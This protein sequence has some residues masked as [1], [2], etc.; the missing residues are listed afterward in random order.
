MSYSCFSV[1]EFCVSFVCHVLLYS[2]DLCFAFLC[3]SVVRQVQ[4]TSILRCPGCT[5]GLKSAVL[6][7]HEQQSL[8]D[9]MRTLY[10]EVRGIL[11]PTL[12]QLYNQ[13]IDHLAHSGD[14]QKDQECYVDAGRQFLI[15]MS[16]DSIYYGRFLDQY[17]DEII[18]DAFQTKR[19]KSGSQ[20]PKKRAK[21]QPLRATRE[22]SI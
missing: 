1:R 6:H 22:S 16:A 2:T 12:P 8:L 21:T 19:K 11:L 5:R 17:V 13:F 18:N 10:E 9:K 15:F 14:E 7:L 3:E 20:N 4:Q